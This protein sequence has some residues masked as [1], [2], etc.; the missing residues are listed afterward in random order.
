MLRLAIFLC[1]LIAPSVAFT[2]EL[3]IHNAS[4]V[5]L[6]IPMGIEESVVVAPGES[7]R[8][9]LP[10]HLWLDFG[11][12]AHEYRIS[13]ANRT[14]LCPPDAPVPV[15]IRAQPGG[16]LWLDSP[17]SQPTGFPLRPSRSTDLTGSPSDNSFKPKLLRNSV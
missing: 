11:A 12:E 4:S 10:K 9:V 2:C 5:D 16:T 7:K 15:K 6:S 3:E 8:F 1:C 13:S 17:T 14:V